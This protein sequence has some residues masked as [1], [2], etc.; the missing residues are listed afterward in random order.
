MRLEQTESRRAACDLCGSRARSL[1]AARDRRGKP[2]RTVLCTRCG[3]VRHW[4]IPTSAELDTFYAH[5]YRQAYHGETTPSDR[6]VLRAWRNGE[7]ICGLLG[8]H[9]PTGARVLEVGAGIGCTVK[10]FELRGWHAS[11]IEPHVG[12]QRYASD[13][14]R[15]DVRN[16]DLFAHCPARPYDAILLVHVIEH[17]RSPRSALERIRE[18]LVPNGLF[19]IE[20]PNL[21]APFAAPGKYF[22]AAHIHNF[23]PATL[24]AMARAAGFEPAAWLSGARDPDLALL[25]RRTDAADAAPIGAQGV[26]EAV[27]GMSRF[28]LWTYHA[29][30]AYVRN[31]ARK[32]AAYLG[33]HVAARTIVRKLRERFGEETGSGK[34]RAA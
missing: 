16:E 32:I 4:H 1:V 3:L 20:C 8:P 9:M 30:V 21:A 28:N 13:V 33:E 23:T 12:F 24:G 31:R 19:Y 5:E 10:N 14:I 6:R 27:D 26:C 25:V 18:L 15:A 11:G 2:L 34:R 17:F 29:R 22:H 7:R